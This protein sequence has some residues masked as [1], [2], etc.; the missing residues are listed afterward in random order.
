MKERTKRREQRSSSHSESSSRNERSYDPENESETD[1]SCRAYD[2]GRGGEDTGSDHSTKGKKGQLE[3][4]GSV[5]FLSFF[6]LT[7]WR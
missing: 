5:P 4:T 6:E 3:S 2:G 7:G 1:G